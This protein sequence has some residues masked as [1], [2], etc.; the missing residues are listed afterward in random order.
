LKIRTTKALSTRS[1][2]D[3]ASPNGFPLSRDLRPN[4]IAIER[5]RPLGRE[6][7]KHPRHQIKKLQRSLSEFGFVFPI[8]ITPDGEVIAG[9]ALVEA[10]LRSGLVEVPAVVI[11]G[12]TEAASH[13]LRIA[14]NRLSDDASW[15]LS[16]LKLEFQDVMMLEPELDLTLSGFEI[17]EIDLSLRSGE[18]VS[19]RADELP[20]IGATLRPVSKL[21]DLWLL[22]GHRVFCG[23]ALDRSSY[24]QVMAVELARLW[25]T[26]PP[27]NVRIVGHAAGRLTGH[28][29]FAMASG[30]MTSEEY[31]AFLSRTLELMAAYSQD[32]ALAF[33]CM[34]WRHIAELCAAAKLFFPE[35]IN[36]CVW[37]KT[38]AGM[39]SLYRSAHELVAI[40]KVGTKPH[41][42]NVQLGRYGRYR[43]NVW[44]YPGMN[45]FGKER[46]E[47]LAG[48]PTVKPVALVEDAILD[49]SNRGDLVLDP[50]IGSGTTLIA[51]ERA[52][53]RC[54]GMDLDPGY[55]DLSL[56]RFRKATGIEPVHQQ[57]GRTLAECEDSQS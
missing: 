20:V 19:D 42:N 22:G 34:D 1:S 55:V 11:T 53:R 23:S 41:I 6:T 46:E 51:A 57:T 8:L 33:I 31:V 30:E 18:A 37:H 2:S 14:L 3:G 49:C 26:D 15:D 16:Q 45:S 56:R 50:F 38:N 36:L 44:T 7:R 40:F 29:E 4:L 32:G 13:T 47:A 48:H 43:T 54:F 5:L 27:Y 9:S 12:L 17:A 25:I 39:G 28:R 24:Q 21:G 35:F 52:G 10:A